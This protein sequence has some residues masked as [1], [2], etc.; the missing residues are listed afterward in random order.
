MKNN[1]HVDNGHIWLST[2]TDAIIVFRYLEVP[3]NV[4]EQR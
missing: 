4:F 3:L 1:L 2:T